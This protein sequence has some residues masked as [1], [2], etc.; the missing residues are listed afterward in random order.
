[1]QTRAHAHTRTQRYGAVVAPE[2]DKF[3]DMVLMIRSS[4]FIGNPAFSTETKWGGRGA[5]NEE[6]LARGSPGKA[7][8]PGCKSDSMEAHKL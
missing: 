5:R 3:V 7:W 2:G 4:F 6:A 8:K 1:M